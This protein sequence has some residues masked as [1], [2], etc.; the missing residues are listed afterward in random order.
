ME[1]S[2]NFS[3]AG[4]QLSLN[5]HF[6]SGLHKVL[7]LLFLHFHYMP[8]AIPSPR[9]LLGTIMGSG[10]PK[11]RFEFW[12]TNGQH[13]QEMLASSSDHFA[14]VAFAAVPHCIPSIRSQLAVGTATECPIGS[15]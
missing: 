1:V 3:G 2:I 11:H 13:N 6:Q 7:S 12:R 9:F 5:A 10:D 8:G 4:G 15:H 14:H